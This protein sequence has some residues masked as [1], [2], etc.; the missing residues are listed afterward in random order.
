M[1]DQLDGR[2][3]LG[4]VRRDRSQE[5][6]ENQAAHTDP[7]GPEVLADA[8]RAGVRTP[9]ETTAASSDPAV[10]AA[11]AFPVSTRDAVAAAKPSTD[12][13]GQ[14]PAVKAVEMGLDSPS[15]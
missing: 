5:T 3:D 13:A 6:A 14:A 11:R 12:A 1:Q 7:F 4:T 10:T 9:A 2:I 15:R 8:E